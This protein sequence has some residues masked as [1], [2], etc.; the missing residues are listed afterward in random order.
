M[1]MRKQNP[2]ERIKN[3]DEV[4]LGLTEQEAVTEAKRCLQCK[5]PLCVE[6]CPVEIDIPAFIKFIAEKKFNE[7]ILKIKEKNNLP[8]VCGRVCPQ[9]DQCE[10]KCVL[11]KKKAAIDIG[12]LE[13]FAADWELEHSTPHPSPLPAA[14]GEGRGEG[15]KVAVIGSGPAGL[16]CAADLARM[17]YNVA[18]FESLHKAGGVLVYGIPEFRLPKA[19]VDREVEYIK[20]LGVEL[21]LNFLI[22]QT[23]TIE[24]LKSEGYKAFFIATGAGL[25]YFLGIPGENLNGIYSANEFLT[26]VNL[27]KGYKFPEYTTPVSTGENVAVVGAGNVAMDCARCAKRL[28]AKNVYIVYRRTEA[29]MPARIE[30]IEN[31]KEEGIIFKLL[32]NPTK[33]FGENGWI[34][35][36][37]CIKNELGA[38]D[39]SG[40][41]RPV[42]IKGSEYIMPIDTLIS[43]IGQGPNPLLI[44]RVQGLK[45]NEDGNIIADENGMT[46]IDGIF[47]GG[48]IVTGA[49]TVIL[50][51][52]AGKKA[53]RAVDSYLKNKGI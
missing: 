49:A 13:R 9:E 20:S 4:A 40:R 17:G 12:S 34:T 10:I 52:G 16:T 50:A 46:S 30:E 5:K 11:H 23:D 25:P 6:G 3:F 35:K 24:D 19:I 14:R 39:A 29:E 41:R 45:L 42:P 32:T 21:K 31:A 53:A 2:L 36:M 44:K 37:E 27:M 33:I 48:D 43:A 1:Q 38:P 47:A 28:G 51:M 18:L 26:R 7:A 8:A 15:Q 22:G